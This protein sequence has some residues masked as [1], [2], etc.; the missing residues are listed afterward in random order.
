MLHHHDF[1][2][3]LSAFRKRFEGL[4]PEAVDLS[5]LSFQEAGGHIRGSEFHGSWTPMAGVGPMAC[6]WQGAPSKGLQEGSGH[7]ASS[8][9]KAAAATGNWA[10]PGLLHNCDTMESSSMLPFYLWSLQYFVGFF[11]FFRTSQMALNC[12]AIRSKTWKTWKK[13]INFLNI[14][15]DFYGMCISCLCW[16]PTNKK[17][18]F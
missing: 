11:F 5:H 17:N 8:S 7:C 2:S 9:W 18:I 12:Q 3:Q 14:K 4:Q 6:A 13:L 1:F 15:I 16:R 10:E